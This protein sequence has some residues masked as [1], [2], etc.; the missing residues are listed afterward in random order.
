[1]KRAFGV[2]ICAGGL[3][4]A[5]QVR[6]EPSPPGR[7][8]VQ[9]VLRDA[10]GKLASGEH[11]I[12]V[13]FYAEEQGGSPVGPSAGAD[14]MP[15]DKGLFTLDV[16][17]DPSSWSSLTSPPYLELTIDNAPSARRLQLSSVPFALIARTAERLAP[18]AIDAPRTIELVAPWK[19]YNLDAMYAP[20]SYFR[21][22]SGVVHLCGLVRKDAGG[23]PP[24]GGST[25]FILPPGFRPRLHEVFSSISAITNQTSAPA[26]GTEIANGVYDEVASIACRVDVLP[27]GSVRVEDARCYRGGRSVSLSGISFR[28]DQ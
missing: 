5:W 7:V 6:A 25:L 26:P 4:C 19:P 28:A 18:N 24:D 12:R 21:D 11:S 1:M 2:L 17:V 22:A 16:D 10:D 23:N 9:G 8:S 3:I 13:A 20:A 14:D 15:I 27:D